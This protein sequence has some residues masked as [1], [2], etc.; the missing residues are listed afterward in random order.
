GI[1]ALVEAAVLMGRMHHGDGWRRALRDP[2]PWTM[3]ATWLGYLAV[4]R[5][6][7]PEFLGA[8][9]PLVMDFYLDQGGQSA[10]QVLLVPRMASALFLLLPML[11]VTLRQ[12]PRRAAALPRILA[13]AAVGALASAMA[14]HKG[15]TYH[16]VPVELLSCALAAVLAARWLDQAGASHMPRGAPRAAAALAGLCALYAIGAGEAPWNQLGYWKSDAAKLTAQLREEAAGER[17]LVLSPAISPIYPAL[18]YAHARMTLRTMNMWVLEG[19]YLACLPNGRRYREVWEMARPEFFIYRTVAED[20]ARA[21]PA[22]V[23]VDKSPGIPWC[24]E[25]F[26]FIA[27]FSRHQLFAEVWSHYEPAG[28]WGRYRVFRR[29]D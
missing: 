18:N 28:E 7:F 26:D 25:E 22:V 14:Q 6:A 17:V 20:F 1:P 27:Y 3:A 10:L 11:V 23:V 9:V 12:T 8:V 5:L 15:W 13:L 16:I 21:P 4:M 24:G 19:A 29:R 2:V